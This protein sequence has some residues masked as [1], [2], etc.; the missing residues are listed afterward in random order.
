MTVSLS[1]FLIEIVSS[2]QASPVSTIAGGMIAVLAILLL[3]ERSVAETYGGAKNK[4]RI[5]GITVLLFPL[6][7]GFLLVAG[8]RLAELL[9]VL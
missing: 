6:L 3:V 8:L 7:I 1:K 4:A 9:K 2:P 5:D